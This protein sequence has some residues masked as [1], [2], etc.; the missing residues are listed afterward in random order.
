M[1]TNHVRCV[2]VRVCVPV[3]VC[4]CVWLCV[5]GCVIVR[6]SAGLA[7]NALCFIMFASP[8]SSA[9]KIVF[10]F[11]FS[12]L[13][14]LSLPPFH[15]SYTPGFRLIPVPAVLRREKQMCC[16]SFLS[17]LFLVLI[18]FAFSYSTDVL[19]FLLFLTR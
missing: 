9:A 7:A 11:S 8:L 12:F 5:C 10:L 19:F 15:H 6:A 1:Y 2:L 13:F 14:F 3:C 18:F 4:L 17:F 16:H